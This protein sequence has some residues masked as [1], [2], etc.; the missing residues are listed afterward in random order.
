MQIKL[1]FLYPATTG[2]NID[3][4]LRVI[5]SLQKA[6]QFK[7]ATPANWK[8]GESV[9]ISPSVT[10]EQA[11]DMFPQGF[12]TVDLPSNKEYLRLT[13]VWF[14]LTARTI[15]PCFHF[16][17]FLFGSVSVCRIFSSP[18]QLSR[19]VA[20]CLLSFVHCSYVIPPPCFF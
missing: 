13:K 9:V 10:N 5:E 2:R 20:I 18:Q 8:P 19:A 14:P 17:Y 16:M 6:S 3:E 15:Q 4:V 7:V 11:K 12:D 1:S